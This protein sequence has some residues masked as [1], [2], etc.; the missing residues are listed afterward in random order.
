MW[1][2]PGTSVMELVLKSPFIKPLLSYIHTKAERMS[3]ECC[4]GSW[5]G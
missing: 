4:E 1:K 2:L 5:G 3:S